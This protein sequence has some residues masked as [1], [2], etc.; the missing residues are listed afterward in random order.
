MT[1]PAVGLFL[2]V[3]LLGLAR[4][5]D[6]GIDRR[7]SRGAVGLA[8]AALVLQIGLEGLRWTLFP[9]YGLTIA[10]LSVAVWKWRRPRRLHRLR[11]VLA[12]A[13]F[14]LGWSIAWIPPLLV[15]VFHLPEPPGDALVG[16]TSIAFVDRDRPET[17]TRRPD[18]R[19]RLSA[20]IWYPASDRGQG[21]RAP[22]M[23]GVTIWFSHWR[24]VR[25]RAWL[26]APPVRREG[27]RPLV[28]FLHGGGCWAVQN[29]IQMEALASRGYVVASLSHPYDSAIT[30]YPSD[31]SVMTRW[32]IQEPVLN[33]NHQ[34]FDRWKTEGIDSSLEARRASMARIHD[35]HPIA[36]DVIERRAEDTRA[37]LEHLA[38]LRAAR[39]EGWSEI[40][41]LDRV[42]L[43]G[44]SNGGAVAFEVARTEPRIGAV[45]NID[46]F[47]FGGAWRDP[48]AHPALV[49]S[50]ER[51]ASNNDVVLA[52]NRGPSYKAVVR[53]AT[54]FNFVTDSYL[55]VSAF[56]D[57]FLGPTEATRVNT[58][59][60][61]LLIAFL[62]HHLLGVETA[63]VT[64]LAARFPELTVSRFPSDDGAAPW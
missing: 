58:I 8:S 52:A 57:R 48:L 50:K 34:A 62:E 64:G 24:P 45:V 4:P 6:R 19:R 28:V 3:A 54:H 2:A 35:A 47:P 53:G 31:A 61:S 59:V 13:V 17:F 37:F 18:D 16:T 39:A 60:D 14:F 10:G 1:G 27:R 55:W 7:I 49:I 43:I 29:T 40:V 22:Y 63:S 46:G 9:I 41:D 21:K 23:E 25:A 15:P 36:R 20:R 44:M 26:D 56:H 32:E 12:A 38:G 51:S 42:A 30:P 33:D 11:R 5:G